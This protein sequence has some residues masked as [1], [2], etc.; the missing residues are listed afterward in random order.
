MPLMPNRRVRDLEL[1]RFLKAAE[2][3]HRETRFAGAHRTRLSVK[4]DLIEPRGQV[5]R[6]DRSPIA[7]G[8]SA[9]Q[10]KFATRLQPTPA[11]C[12]IADSSAASTLPRPL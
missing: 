11:V 2:G 10:V 1:S 7:C 12:R 9:T 3:H 6:V 8:P 4:Y 5:I